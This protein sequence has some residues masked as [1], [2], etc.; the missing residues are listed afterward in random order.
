MFRS[1]NRWKRLLAV[2]LAVLLGLA[3]VPFSAFAVP[4]ETPE[5]NQE[6][7][8]TADWTELTDRRELAGRTFSSGSGS[9]VVALYP[10][11]VFYQ[12]GEEGDLIPYDYRLE[13]VS[14]EEDVKEYRV[15]DGSMESSVRRFFS[16]G[17]FIK[18][19]FEGGTMALSLPTT[20]STRARIPEFK[21]QAGLYGENGGTA[22][23]DTVA[24]GHIRNYGLCE[25]ALSGI[26]IGVEQWPGN[27]VITAEFQ[28][29][30][31]AG[32]GLVLAAAMKGLS[33]TEAA[34]GSLHFSYQG[35]EVA[36]LKA[37][38]VYDAKR[39]M[40][41]ASYMLSSR[42][43]G[44]TQ[45]L[46]K[47]DDEWM[48]DLSRT[49]PIT[50]HMNFMQPGM[51]AG[52][53]TELQ[54]TEGYFAGVPVAAG[55][56]KETVQTRVALP[57]LPA[58]S[59]GKTLEKVSLVLSR[60]EDLEEPQSS[61][62]LG[63]Y[64]KTDSGEL[65]LDSVKYEADDRADACILDVTTAYGNNGSGDQEV[66]LK[67]VQTELVTGVYGFDFF[68]SD[69]LLP[70]LL[71]SSAGEKEEAEAG[72]QRIVGED[73]ELR[74]PFTKHFLTEAGGR[75]AAVY[76]VPV[77]FRKDGKWEEIDNTL[78]L[79]EEEEVYKNRA[80]DLAAAFAKDSAAGDLAALQFDGA[81]CSWAFLEAESGEGKE[82]VPETGTEEKEP[83][84]DERYLELSA[85]ADGKSVS[86]YNAELMSRA[87]LTGGGVYPDVLEHV[88]IRYV[89]DSAGLTE[90]ILFRTKEAAKTTLRFLVRH[91]GL[92]IRLEPDGSVAF[93][94]AGETV[95]TFAAPCLYD[96]SGDTSSEVRFRLEKESSDATILVI[97]P[98]QEWLSESGRTYPV[99]I[100]RTV[101]PE[102]RRALQTAFVRE[103]QPGERSEETV[104]LPVG[105][106]S[107]YGISRTFLKFLHLPKL[108]YGERI[109]K[110]I[111][112]LYQSQYVSR[113]TSDFT[114]AAHPV[115]EEWDK[116]VTWESQPSVAETVLDSQKAENLKT[117]DAG[118]VV[119]KQFDVTGQVSAW[120]GKENYGLMLA[121]MKEGVKAGAAYTVSNRST[122]SVPY[123]KALYPTGLFYYQTEGSVPGT[124]NVSRQD[125]SQ[126]GTGYVGKTAGSLMFVHEDLGGAGGRLP[127]GFGHVYS[128]ARSGEASSFGNGWRLTVTE[129]LEA[130]GLSELPY[131]YVDDKGEEHF[132]RPDESDDGSN[133]YTDGQGLVLK[134][135]SSEGN[136]ERILSGEDGSERIF[137][138]AGR[139]QQKKSTDGTVLF[140]NYGDED[141]L[142][143]LSDTDGV[144]A[145]FTYDTESG[146]LLSLTD[147]TTGKTLSYQYDF[148]GNLTGI[149]HPDGRRSI[150]AY[151]ERRMIL[152]KAA[153]GTAVEYLYGEDAGT[154]RVSMIREWKGGKAGITSLSYGKESVS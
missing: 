2:V 100:E 109:T 135:E 62:E 60:A 129:E 97:E 33:M 47:P 98:D 103:E 130:T 89:L 17:E 22:A 148:A 138:A 45:I 48:E 71:V 99:A 26:D 105:V 80:S 114:A 43:D 118:T 136:G 122:R 149:L 74:D 56:T 63:V 125:A 150:Y 116:T 90:S 85:N 7:N 139:L 120:Y 70:M 115:S 78:V 75:L 31:R 16:G 76:E 20:N 61:L 87:G 23:E 64:Q 108:Q 38:V 10:Y 86:A 57:V 27:V 102:G 29:A 137:D 66:L 104:P 140:Y 14:G 4:E 67:S 101:E 5:E 36:V 123:P 68:V 128:L 134:G 30:S 53:T 88:D 69:M 113:R 58:L 73:R 145:S 12:D 51:E 25:E 59:E 15:R 44:A 127:A 34:D 143:S 144:I 19:G 28:K 77:H 124:D 131:R 153:D 37:P 119:L 96:W 95:Y 147:E 106:L 41:K 91:P 3:A 52:I 93:T 94:R 49:S 40:G 142:V 132:F 133:Q 42:E 112:N 35:E 24:A 50:I 11:P 83:S 1:K 110:G 117:K 9:E 13:L 154:R 151:D 72:Q 32:E 6:A 46:V 146:R 55:N 152:A 54:S 141:R 18:F 81:G 82:F 92:E 126:A 39:A 111:L 84:G 21:V 107:G 121:S 8:Q 79:D 65:L